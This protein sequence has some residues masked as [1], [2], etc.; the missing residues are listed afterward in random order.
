MVR[1]AA[2]DATILEVVF[3]RTLYAPPLSGNAVQASP[4]M[5]KK[6]HNRF[7]VNVGSVHVAVEVEHTADKQQTKRRQLPRA[8]RAKPD[9]V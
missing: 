8:C 2:S 3:N 9:G 6:L 7:P 1:Q 5:Q 4:Y